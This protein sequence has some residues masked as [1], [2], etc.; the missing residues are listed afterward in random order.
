MDETLRAAGIRMAA[1]REAQ[2]ALVRERKWKIDHYDALRAAARAV[3]ERWEELTYE[4]PGRIDDPI[5]DRMDAL[6]EAL[7]Q[8]GAA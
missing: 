6:R 1:A 2:E 7:E 4:L 8:A 5:N 3:V